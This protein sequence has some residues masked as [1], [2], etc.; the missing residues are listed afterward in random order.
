MSGETQMN[1][2]ES[3]RVDEIVKRL[4][5]PNR[6]LPPPE[7]LSRERRAELTEKLLPSSQELEVANLLSSYTGA[8]TQK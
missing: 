6:I 5:D 2:R 8:T 4:T 3:K 1:K 7:K